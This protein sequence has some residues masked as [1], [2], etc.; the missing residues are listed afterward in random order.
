MFDPKIFYRQMD[1]LLARIGRKKSGQNF[2]A[3]IIKV[4]EKDVGDMLHFKNGRLYE[5]RDQNFVLIHANRRKS[6]VD[7]TAMDAK[8]KEVVRVLRTGAM[9]LDKAE[10]AR[11]K[12]KLFAANTPSI[13]FSLYGFNTIW[14]A[15]FELTEG[16]NRE[17]VLFYC[18]A[19]RAAL[20]HRLLAETV[21]NDMQRAARVQH[22][23]LPLEP[24]AIPGY[25]ISGNSLPAEAV[26]GDFFD[27]HLVNGTLGLIFGDAS[28]H[29]L[30][31]ALLVRDVI[32]GM[33]M[34]VAS[35]MKMVS[36]LK[37]L[38]QVVQQN[39]YSTRFV[40]LFYG[41]I[42]KF[43]VL[44]FVNCGHPPPIVVKGDRIDRLAA[45]GTIL[46]ALPKVTLHRASIELLPGA[47][48][49]FY[50]DGIIESENENK[51]KFGIDRMT[52]LVVANQNNTAGEIE[53]SIFDAVRSYSASKRLK[54]DATAL[55]LK[56]VS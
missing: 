45:T 41:E 29:G 9:V 3:S 17:Q 4:L 31:A 6:T 33:R 50:S 46:G 55:V 39:T 1:A 10:A 5:R 7:V 30:P 13:L 18:N 53:Q 8:A 38:N 28:G 26:G 12:T 49:V 44:T 51:E 23:L 24:P 35:G 11:S 19:L 21:E 54:D 27:F 36:L 52:E 37:T 34:G 14:L 43:G 32:T 42:E 2:L 22:S 16:W 40:S 47:V 15:L 48:L 20:N 25:Q 56:R